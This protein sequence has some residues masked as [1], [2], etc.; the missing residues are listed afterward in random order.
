MR[1]GGLRGQAHAGV[2]VRSLHMY[3]GPISSVGDG[4]G[5]ADVPDCDGEAPRKDADVVLILGA[6]ELVGTAVLL[7][8]MV[9]VSVPV[10]CP[11]PS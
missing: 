4:A 3:V 10:A 8:E 11:G 5:D 9:P 6:V 2:A 1:L 7:A